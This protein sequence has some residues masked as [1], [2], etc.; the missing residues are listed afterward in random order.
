MLRY[1]SPNSPPTAAAC[2]KPV[3]DTLVPIARIDKRLTINGSTPVTNH[4]CHV[5]HVDDECIFVASPC[6]QS[7]FTR[8]GPVLEDVGPQPSIPTPAA[9][10][11]RGKQTELPSILKVLDGAAKLARSG[12][13][14]AR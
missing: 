8:L 9:F 5:A 2:L 4:P 13:G 1:L 10:A 14:E 12:A 6:I 3:V 11:G 7:I